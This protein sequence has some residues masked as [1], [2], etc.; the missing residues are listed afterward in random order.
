MTTIINHNIEPTKEQLAYCAGFFDGEGTVI[1]AR[2]TNSPH[3][4]YAVHVTV[5]QVNPEPLIL[6][7]SLFGGT[8]YRARR[9][10]IEANGHIRK[11]QWRWSVGLMAA[12]KFLRLIVPYL[13]NKKEEAQLAIKFREDCINQSN[14]FTHPKYADE[15]IPPFISTHGNMLTEENIAL[16]EQYRQSIMALKRR[17]Y[18]NLPSDTF[19]DGV[20]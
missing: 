13:I 8:V 17:E 11:I 1:I 16:R 2:E 9:N 6:F 19:I 20:L 3:K 10:P 4:Y 14:K 5:D 15:S 12:D 18:D 7:R